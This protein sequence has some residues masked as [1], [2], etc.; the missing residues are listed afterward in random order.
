MWTTRTGATAAAVLALAACSDG[1]A[2]EATI[3]RSTLAADVAAVAAQ[4]TA[5]D[6]AELALTAEM[7]VFTLPGEPGPPPGAGRS[8]DISR[9]REVTFYDGAGAEMDGYDPLLTATVVSVLEVLAERSGGVF[10]GTMERHRETEVTGLE[11][12]ETSRTWN[13]LGTDAVSR[14]RFDDEDGDRSYDM[15]GTVTIADVVVGVP[16]SENPW[17]LSGTI[18]RELSVEIVNGPEGDATFERTAV[19]TFDGTRFATVVVDGETFEIDLAD[20]NRQRPRRRGG[21][22][23]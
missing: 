8:G 9:S 7:G 13:G 15:S 20:R 22:G 4:A 14:T 16:R 6:V 11:G 18:T 23:G 2:P 5:E 12:E 3:D 21:R 10:E 1:T 19:V 17:P